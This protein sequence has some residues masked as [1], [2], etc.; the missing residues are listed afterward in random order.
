MNEMNMGDM[1]RDQAAKIL[2]GVQG[3]LERYINR[4]IGYVQVRE[5]AMSDPAGYLTLTHTPVVKV[6]SHSATQSDYAA[7]EYWA[8]TPVL[9]I[10]RDPLLG[11]TGKVIDYTQNNVGSP[12]IVPGGVY[13]G[14]VG[15]WF[16]IEYIAGLDPDAS[17]TASGESIREAIKRVAAR[18]AGV[19][20]NDGLNLRQGN[21]ET[22]SEKDDRGKGWT[23]EELK[24]FDRIR[25]RTVL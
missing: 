9:P 21:A 11:D 22:A 24:L 2:A 17:F 18:D 16:F 5:Y 25:R 19:Q 7:I 4:P 20:F 1:D 10:V 15:A 23:E 14:L 6:I 13:V 8:Y 3:D 12:L